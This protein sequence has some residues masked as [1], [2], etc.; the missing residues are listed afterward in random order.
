MAFRI[1]KEPGYWQDTMDNRSSHRDGETTLLL[2]PFG[3]DLPLNR[4]PTTTTQSSSP[5]EYLSLL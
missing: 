4:V 2:L 5:V 1:E 3:H